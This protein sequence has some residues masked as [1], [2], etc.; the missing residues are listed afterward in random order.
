MSKM[1]RLK[2][3][4]LFTLAILPIA[5][6]GSILVS[7]YTMETYTPE[8]TEAILAS[9]GSMG[10]FVAVASAQGAVYAAIAG[11]FGYILAD[12]LGLM[13]PLRFE[14][15]ALKRALA[16]TAACGLLFSLDPYLFGRLIPE[17]G[18]SYAGS[19]TFANFFASL[20]YGGIVEEILMR[21]FLMSLIAFLLWK[22]FARKYSRE[23]IP[24]WVFVVA[25]VVAALLFA[26]G[27]IPATIS[28]FGRLDAVILVRCFLLNGAFG[29]AFGWLYRK[30][31]I[32]Y[33]IVG[34]MGCHFVSKLIWLVTDLL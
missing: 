11:F 22:V 19:V 20:I 3:P 33:A 10:A 12:R 27:H 2:K 17:V 21:L 30:Y 4:L 28:M 25:N 6:I 32:Q 23:A 34:H 9:V 15:Q 18:A 26:A 8:M 1:S 5:I 14:K 7:Y 31:G 29:L 13:R 16:V 24:T